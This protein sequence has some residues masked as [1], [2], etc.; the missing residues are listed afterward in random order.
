MQ[1]KHRASQ[2]V[3]GRGLPGA[4]VNRIRIHPGHS[5]PDRGHL[6]LF[7]AQFAPIRRVRGQPRDAWTSYCRNK[8]MRQRTSLNQP[9]RDPPIVVTILGRTRQEVDIP[10]ARRAIIPPPTWQAQVALMPLAQ[11]RL[12]SRRNKSPLRGK[13]DQ[14]L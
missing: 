14:G 4:T 12:W 3:R 7:P 9:G 10:E 1:L 13:E 5:R 11:R 6:L 2:D 8:T